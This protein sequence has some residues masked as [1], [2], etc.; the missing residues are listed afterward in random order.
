VKYLIIAV[1]FSFPCYGQNY[2]VAFSPDGGATDLIV[3]E[4]LSAKKSVHMAAFTF[5]SF[6]IVH[7]LQYV[8]AGGIDVKIV[9]D[10]M[11][12]SS[13]IIP[14][15]AKEHIPYRFNSKYAIFHHKFMVIDGKTI[16]TGSMNYTYSAE[17]KNAENVLII[18]DAPFAAAY[19]KEFQ[20]LWQEGVNDTAANV[21][22]LRLPR[23]VKR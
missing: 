10:D 1:L 9:M 13:P 22:R 18:E 3:E 21:D 23:R 20:R 5:T 14:E 8:K 6:P 11:Q 16:E 12:K 15:L 19:E 7:A 4:I 2:K 17:H